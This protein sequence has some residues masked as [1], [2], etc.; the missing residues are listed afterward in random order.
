MTHLFKKTTKEFQELL[1][2][3]LLRMLNSKSESYQRTFR[4]Q[5]GL[6]LQ[7]EHV[8][9]FTGVNDIVVQPL[10]KGRHLFCQASSHFVQLFHICS[11]EHTVKQ[12]ISGAR[13]LLFLHIAHEE[14]KTVSGQRQTD[15]LARVSGVTLAISHTH[16]HTSIQT[17]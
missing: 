8:V 5:F 13:R 16:K 10:A 3:I 2:Q 12:S 17:N 15:R 14:T 6:S 7:K 9:C 4:E 11:Q 1:Q